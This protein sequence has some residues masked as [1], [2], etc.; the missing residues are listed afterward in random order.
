MDSGMADVAYGRIVD[1]EDTTRRHR[2]NSVAHN[3]PT[4][5]LENAMRLPQPLGQPPEAGACPHC[6]QPLFPMAE[7][8]EIPV[9]QSENV[10]GSELGCRGHR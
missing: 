2:W 10:P 9:T 4:A 8:F 3:S 6:P 5:D 1:D 7:K